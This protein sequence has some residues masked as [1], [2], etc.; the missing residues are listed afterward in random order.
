MV[1]AE[2][3]F[4]IMLFRLELSG[5]GQAFE[6][7]EHFAKI[8]D[9]SSKEINVPA[10]RVGLF[11]SSDRLWRNSYWRAKRGCAARKIVSRAE[12]DESVGHF[13]LESKIS[14]RCSLMKWTKRA[15]TEKYI[16][17]VDIL[18]AGHHRE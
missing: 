16:A 3:V 15:M 8:V 7:N 18:A 1:V 5:R 4:A 2:G 10:R 13:G 17:N 9:I 12:V 6:A 14:F 11:R